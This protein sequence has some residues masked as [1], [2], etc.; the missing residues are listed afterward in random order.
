MENPQQW[1]NTKAEELKA[2]PDHAERKKKL[3]EIKS[4]PEYKESIKETTNIVSV[5][6]MIP[7]I[8]PEKEKAL[9]NVDYNTHRARDTFSH[10]FIEY[11]LKK[12][13]NDPQVWPILR[14]RFKDQIVI[15]LGAGDTN[16]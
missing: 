3:E 6:Q 7:S 13:T 16:T 14:E 1:R 8:K 9:E 12:H 11:V 4:T 5:E 10:D 2:I 15:D